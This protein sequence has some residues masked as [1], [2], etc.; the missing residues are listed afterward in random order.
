LHAQMM[1][2]Q[3]KCPSARDRHSELALKA[4]LPLRRNDG[5]ASN[6][7]QTDSQNFTLAVQSRLDTPMDG[8]SNTAIGTDRCTLGRPPAKPSCLAKFTWPAVRNQFHTPKPKEGIS[9]WHYPP[10]TVLMAAC[11]RCCKPAR[12]ATQVTTHASTAGSEPR[13]NS[14][15]IDTTSRHNGQ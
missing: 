1:A 10:P 12:D 3:M 7:A 2:V 15:D 11:Y 5:L 9:G 13:L 6:Q 8:D 14:H 4:A